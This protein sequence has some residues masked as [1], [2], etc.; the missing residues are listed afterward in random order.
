MPFNT[1]KKTSFKCPGLINWSNQLHTSYKWC[2]WPTPT[3]KG[4]KTSSRKRNDRWLEWG[5]TESNSIIIIIKAQNKHCHHQFLFLCV[6]VCDVVNHISLFRI[7]CIHFEQ[8]AA[9]ESEVRAHTH[10]HTPTHEFCPRVLFSFSIPRLASDLATFE[11]T[12]GIECGH[13]EKQCW[14]KSVW[15][16]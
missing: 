8:C 12:H 7:I 6:C 10:T 9:S 2:L 13:W 3:P 1:Q 15:N 5:E 4:K 11:S 14:T 16:E